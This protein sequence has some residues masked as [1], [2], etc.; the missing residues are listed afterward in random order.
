VG[1]FDVPT[2]PLISVSALA[3][4]FDLAREAGTGDIHQSG[5][6]PGREPARDGGTLRI[7]DV[8][9]RL[10]R[11][12]GSAE[13]REGHIPGAVYVDLDT[14]LAAHGAPT[15]GRH[16]LPTLEQLVDAARSW[17]L[18][19][20]DRVVVYDDFQS[21]P[22]SR[23]WWL[24][25]NAGFADVRVLDGGLE[26]WRSAGHPVETGERTAER[27]TVELT[28]GNLPTIGL[29]DAAKFPTAGVLLDARAPERYRGEVEPMDPRAGHIPGAI[30]APASINFG[31]DG[32]FLSPEQL[33][34]RY[35]A[36]GVV[37]GVAVASYCGSGVTASQTVL[38][39]S[40]AGISSALFPGSWSQWSQHPELPAATGSPST[41]N[42]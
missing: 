5:I 10:D 37:D 8:R 39:L 19:V 26:A 21:V 6:E 25:T 31:P 34:E 27:G 40:I 22:A 24:L 12:N 13:Y 20:G 42:L 30:N 4:E 23:A 18:N 1:Q 41:L 29:A 14:E 2:N 28:E 32:M 17:G 3:H 33:R 9:W 38:A 35:A 11:P 7:L 36:L 16:P 15:D